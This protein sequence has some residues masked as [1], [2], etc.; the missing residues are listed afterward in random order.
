[1]GESKQTTLIRGASSGIGRE[2]WFLER[3]S[4]LRVGLFKFSS[5]SHP[6]AAEPRPLE[7]QEYNHGS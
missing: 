6:Q 7:R 4:R 2:T 1:V 5:L 3:L